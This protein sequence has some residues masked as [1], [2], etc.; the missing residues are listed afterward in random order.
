MKTILNFYLL[1]TALF[2]YSCE[3]QDILSNESDTLINTEAINCDLNDLQIINNPG[4]TENYLI[5]DDD[6]DDEKINKNLFQLSLIARDLLKD[7]SFNNQI[8]KAVS[9]SANSTIDLRKLDFSLK[10][11]NIKVADFI[12]M[13]KNIDLTHLS[14]NPLKSG[15]IENYIPC[16]F[17]PN[18]EVAD[19][20]KNPIICPGIEVNSELKGLDG[21]EDYIVAW[22]YDNNDSLME[23]I[24]N[25]QMV[26]NTKHPVYILDN[27]EELLTQSQKSQEQI[28]KSNNINFKSTQSIKYFSSHEYQINER[29]ESSGDSEFCI[30]GVYMTPA[31]ICGW[32][33]TSDYWWKISDVN[34]NDIGKPLSKWV[35]FNYCSLEPFDEKLTYINAFERDWYGSEKTL[36]HVPAYGK[37]IYLSGNMNHSGD[38]YLYDPASNIPLLDMAPIYDSWAGWVTSSKC[39]LRIWRVE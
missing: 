32:V 1:V 9:L 14:K 37:T 10:S 33:H 7:K 21:Y 12:K 3:E 4:K 11:S 15:E 22:Y 28:Q 31:G 19:F 8:K 36:G 34:K 2:L 24:V 39:E 38:W 18:A 6:F 29:Y 5:N 25:E 13:V 16:I 27:A 20:N 30:E 23:I 17:V 26:M 35:P